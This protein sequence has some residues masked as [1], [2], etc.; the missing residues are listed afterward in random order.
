[1]LSPV[2]EWRHRGAKRAR[3][4]RV[5]F[6]LDPAAPLACL[7]DVVEERAGLPVV[8]GSLQPGVDG[9]CTGAP[10]E[11]TLWLNTHQATVRRRFTL[12][13]ELGHVR[14]PHDGELILD[15]Y[16][17]L[18]GRTTDQREVEANAF[19]AEFLIPKVA[20]EELDPEPDLDALVTL[21]ARFGTSAIMTLFR[22]TTCKLVSDQRRDELKAQIYEDEHFAAQERLELPLIDDRLAR[23]DDGEMY[24]SPRLD[25]T[26]LAATMRGEASMSPALANAVRGLLS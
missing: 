9:A 20:M 11:R 21:A 2:S 22:F 10:T 12:A 26:L 24:V 19:A 4:A 8:I 17:T 1:M 15:T 23:L 25:G 7:L 14:V 6:E 18:A 5:D 16:E 3:T 13:H